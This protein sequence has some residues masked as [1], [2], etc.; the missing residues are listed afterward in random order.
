MN[1]LNEKFAK[2]YIISSYNTQNRLNDLYPFFNQENIDVEIVIG[3]KKK[4]IKPDYTK[5]NCSEG[6]QSHISA[7]ESIFLK[8][9]YLKSETFCIMEDDVFFD[10]NYKNKVDKFFSNLPTDWDVVNLGYHEYTTLNINYGFPT[11]KI[12][13]GERITG[14]HILGYKHHTVEFIKNVIENCVWPWDWFLNDE[15]YPHFNTYVP[16]ERIFY[17]SSYRDCDPI[18]DFNYPKYKS[19]VLPDL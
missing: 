11:Y 8:E 16:T 19:S 2:L 13:K 17:A 10:K 4:Y 6:T 1:I 15:V 12:V 3:P 14:A 7:T 9:S 18:Q 5:T